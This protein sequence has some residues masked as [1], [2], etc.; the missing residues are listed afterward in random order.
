MGDVMISVLLR[1]L[2]KLPVLSVSPAR[3]LVTVFDES[4]LLKSFVLADQLRSAGLAVINSTEA[5]KLPKQL[6]LADRLGIRFAVI[7]GPDESERNEVTIKDL[8]ER[9]QVTVSETEMVAKIQQMLA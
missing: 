4:R 1:E 9:T 5:V 8:V 2:G 3:V 7:Q 6:K